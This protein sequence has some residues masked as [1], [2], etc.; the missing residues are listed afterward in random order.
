MFHSMTTKYERLGTDN[1][2]IIVFIYPDERFKNV[3]EVDPYKEASE[4]Q[5]ANEIKIDCPSSM[6]V[7]NMLLYMRAHHCVKFLI[8][9][10]NKIALALH[11]A[12]GLSGLGIKET[13]I[14]I[15]EYAKSNSYINESLC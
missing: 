11:Q 15:A 4:E 8:K 9:D 10:V 7:K 12:M 14:R 3:Y 2:N 6:E 13:Y 5:K 1:G